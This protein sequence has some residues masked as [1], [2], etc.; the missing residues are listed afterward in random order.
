MN[1]LIIGSTWKLSN[2]GHCAYCGKFTRLYQPHDFKEKS[3]SEKWL[4]VVCLKNKFGID[5]TKDKTT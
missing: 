1:I 5:I 2:D 4:C 3:K